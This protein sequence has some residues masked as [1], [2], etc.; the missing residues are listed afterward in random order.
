MSTDL[1][2]DSGG[3]ERIRKWIAR[4]IEVE[5][6]DRFVIRHDT[7]AEVATLRADDGAAFERTE[8][9]LDELVTDLSER[10][11]ED[12]LGLGGLQRYVISAYSGERAVTRLPLRR[13][14]TAEA[15]RGPAPGDPI[16]SEP[17][18]EKGLLSQ[19]MRH[20]EISERTHA[21]AIANI[22]AMQTRMLREKDERILPPGVAALGQRSSRPSSSSASSHRRQPSPRTARP[23]RRPR[24]CAR[25]WAPSCSWPRRRSTRSPAA[26]LLPQEKTSPALVGLRALVGPMKPGATSRRS[27]FVLTPAQL[28]NLSGIVSA[29]VA[30]EEQ[31]LNGRSDRSAP[32]AQHLRESQRADVRRR[33]RD[34]MLKFDVQATGRCP[35][36]P[37]SSTVPS[38]PAVA[39]SSRGRPNAGTTWDVLERRSTAS[40]ACSR[41]T[42]RHEVDR[43]PSSARSGVRSRPTASV[44]SPPSRSPLGA[45]AG[46]WQ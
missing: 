10:V 13:G 28:E 41:A 43:S 34:A 33:S 18:S 26:A 36:T 4:A 29:E 22:F 44:A 38:A 46:A 23:T 2:R 8:R 25:S 11:F 35:K 19:T 12:A 9:Q 21:T 5:S 24:R 32:I 3:D 16:D 45:P 39:T 31:K 6:I 42:T 20:L 14:N 40:R 7:G 17:P 30:D 1:E 37:S 15:E 27:K